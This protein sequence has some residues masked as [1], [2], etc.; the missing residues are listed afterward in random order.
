MSDELKLIEEFNKRNTEAFGEVYL[1]LYD[2]IVTFADRL[3][4]NTN[5]DSEDAVSAVFCELWQKTSIHFESLQQISAYLYTAVRNDF[6]D[7]LK[8]LN[9]KERYADYV[10]REHELFEAAIIESDVFAYLNNILS[11]LPEESAYIMRRF[12]EGYSTDEI[13]DE[14]GK[15]KRTI[16]NRKHEIIKYLKEKLSKSDFML[17]TM[18][19][20]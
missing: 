20:I 9:H 18:L 1:K 7:Y 17:I 6:K 14:V 10:E 16:Y 8:H 19:L 15:S 2:R 4:L 5:V 3:Y 11:L 12:F 13:A